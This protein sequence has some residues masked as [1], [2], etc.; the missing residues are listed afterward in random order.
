[1]HEL[2]QEF[3][4]LRAVKGHFQGGSLNPDVDGWMGLKHRVMIELGSRLGTG[5]C[6]RAEVIALL[7]EPD[8]IARPGDIA[9]DLVGRQAA[10]PP[11]AEYELLLYYWRGGHDYLYFTAQ[12]QSILGSGWWHAYE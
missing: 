7:G 4:R 9:F 3:R 11:G 5:E 1:M 12:G 6:S 2:A 10:F 8:A